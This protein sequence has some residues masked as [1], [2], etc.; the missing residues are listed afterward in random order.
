MHTV[1]IG[2]SVPRRG[3]KIMQFIADGMF[4]SAGWKITG[5]IPNEKKFI[6]V[7]APHTSNWDFILGLMT[8][9]SLRMEIHWMGKHTIF[10][11]PF[12]GLMKWMGGIPINRTSASGVVSETVSA[13]KENE[14]LV[15]SIAPE[16]TRKKVNKWK[17]GFYFIA[18]KAE[19]PIVIA[20]IDYGKK[21]IE[22]G[23]KID[24]TDDRD[25]D[26]KKI[27]DCFKNVTPKHVDKF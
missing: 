25:G 15:I 16:G 8:L 18:N 10:R 9:F 23:P 21:E 17:M 13:F 27:M 19:I 1:K 11:K 24:L 26:I 22:F 3:A 7:V 4:K 6:V 5:E 20:K 14:K 12:G 2:N